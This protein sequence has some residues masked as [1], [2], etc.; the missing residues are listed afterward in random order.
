MDR[1]DGVPIAD[2]LEER[3]FLLDVAH[4]MLGSQAA[5]ERVVEETYLRWYQLPA[6][7][8][9]TV[10]V[11]RSWLAKTA[12]AIC[13]N[14]LAQ[15]GRGA[16]GH[17][18]HHR[19]LPTG[20]AEEAGRIVLDTL[21]S[22]S[23]EERASFM[24]DSG[25]APGTVAT[26]V[27]RTE[28]DIAELTDRARQWLRIRRAPPTTPEQ[29]D[30]VARAV[31]GACGAQDCEA[32]SSLLCPDVVAFF[33]GGGKI[34]V[35]TGPVHG[36]GPVADGLSALLSDDPRTSLTTH[37]INGRTGLVAR[38]GRQVVAVISLDVLDGRVAQVWVTLNPD[39][40]RSWNRAP[41]GP[42]RS[43]GS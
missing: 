20:V 26:V 5:A 31:L 35:P 8:R 1:D 13:L 34:R 25:R 37:S 23:P 6:A 38:Y 27:G 14:R 36:S 12:G 24:L 3:R 22:L 2:L 19:T 43:A 39:K 11:P 17:E 21:K 40:L 28:A 29:Q 15:S 42:W 10:A 30:A 18:E 32:L 4:W 9:R 16:A 33:D 7:E 41:G